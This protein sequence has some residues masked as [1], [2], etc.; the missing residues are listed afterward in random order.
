MI[1]HQL[2]HEHLNFFRSK[3]K[4]QDYYTTTQKMKITGVSERTVRSRL[5]VLKKKYEGQPRFL[6]KNEK[7]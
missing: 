6:Y 4:L 7:Q 3:H 2:Y 5:V 1:P